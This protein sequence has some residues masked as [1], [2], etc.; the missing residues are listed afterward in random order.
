MLDNKT[1]IDGFLLGNVFT[2]NNGFTEK[3]GFPTINVSIRYKV[4]IQL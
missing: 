4:S 3:D 2:R 1:L